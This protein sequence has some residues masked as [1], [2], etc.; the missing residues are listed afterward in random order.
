MSNQVRLSFRMLK[1]NSVESTFFI[2]Y[3]WSV[4]IVYVGKSVIRAGSSPYLLLRFL[5]EKGSSLVSSLHVKEVSITSGKTVSESSKRVASSVLYLIKHTPGFLISIVKQIIAIA[6]GLFLGIIHMIVSFYS[7]LTSNYFRYFLYG[8]FF[9]L[10]FIFIQQAYFFV[11]ELPSPSTIGQVNFAQSTHLYDRNGKLLYEIYRDVNRTSVPLTSVPKTV[12]QATVAIEDKNFYNHKGISFFGGVLRAAKDTFIY[13]ELQGGSTITQQLVKTALLTPERTIERKLKE[14]VLALWTEQIYTKDEIMEMYLNQVPYGGS[15]YGIEEASKVYFGKAAQ[16]LTLGEAA[17]LAGL[18]KAPSIYSPFIDPDLAKRRRD[19]VLQEMYAQ[20]YISKDKFENAIKEDLN[21]LP[22]TTNI[23]APHFVMYTRTEL[24]NEF[25]T[26]KVEESG[27]NVVTS[28]DLD[29]QQKAEEILQE[30]LKKLA[31]LN[32]SNGGIVVID[33]NNGQILAMVGSADYFGENYG[34]FNVTTAQRQ[35]GSTLKPMLYAMALEN[36]YTAATPIDDSPI[37]FNIAGAEPYQPV[38]Y[39]RRYHGRVPIRY[40]L[41][42][43]YNIPAIKVLNTLGVQPFV[44]FAKTM[45]VD[46]WN[47]SSRFGLSVALGGGEVT[48]LDLAQVYSVFANGG[49]RVEPTPFVE[50]KDSREQEVTHIRSTKTRVLDEGVAFI[51]SDILSDNT[52]RQQAFGAN[53]PLYVPGEIVSAKT[54]TTNDYKDAWTVGFTDKVVVGVWVGNNN[55]SSMHSIAGSLGAG[56]IFNK[57]MKYMIEEHGAEGKMSQPINVVSMP[58]YNGRVEYF[59]RGT[60]K[61]SYCQRTVIKQGDTPVQEVRN[62]NP[63]P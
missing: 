43:S 47:D 9:C 6:E 28:L 35:P 39:D 7:F 44:D 46:T 51:I 56:P 50:I 20:Q 15:A 29:I 55:N 60:E 40:A 2:L 12:I 16:E 53:N 11:R 21:V 18:P 19:Q 17:L 22:P 45:G 52:A 58:C 33:P 5:Y 3:V 1:K 30:E 42:N 24:E 49:Y 32:A 23:R 54:G 41:G 48:L 13:N 59:L 63:Q 14:M 62:T 57:M 36:G 26:K 25:G 34:A 61:Q 27:F 37:V 38:N 8:F 31:P 4:V 10:L